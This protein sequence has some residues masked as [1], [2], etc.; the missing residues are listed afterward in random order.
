MSDTFTFTE[1]ML[2]GQIVDMWTGWS[3]RIEPAS[4]SSIGF[5][6]LI[7]SDRVEGSHFFEVKAGWEPKPGYIQ[8]VGN[9]LRPAQI[10]WHTMF[11]LSGG[12]SGILIGTFDGETTR[13]YLAPSREAPRLNGGL[14]VLEDNV[15]MLAS[16]KKPQNF[17]RLLLRWIKQ[18]KA[19][20]S[21]R[22]QGN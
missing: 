14:N 16:S 7:L 1:N 6:D 17:T 11:S 10:R 13:Y 8:L 2:V 18:E 12:V 9:G 20:A 21:S 19:L 4:G 15:M 3:D 5:P 22:S